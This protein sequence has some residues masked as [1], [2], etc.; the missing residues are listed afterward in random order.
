MYAVG[1]RHASCS[2]DQSDCVLVS[3]ECDWLDVLFSITWFGMY[4]ICCACNYKTSILFDFPVLKCPA[5][6]V[7]NTLDDCS[8]NEAKRQ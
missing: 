4:C 8:D 1:K 6:S 5:E 2:C 3:V 7:S